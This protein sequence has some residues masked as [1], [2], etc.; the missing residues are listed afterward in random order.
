MAEQYKDFKEW[1][2]ENLDPI[3]QEVNDIIGSKLNDNNVISSWWAIFYQN[4]LA[5]FE[6]IFASPNYSN[7]IIMTLRLLMEIA[8]DV[9]F[10]SKNPEN[11]PKL[12]KRY[13]DLCANF[14]TMTYGEVGTESRKFRLYHFKNGKK[15]GNAIT[16]EERIIEAYNEDGV[17]FYYYLNGFSHFN[18]FGIMYGM[19]LRFNQGA[20]NMIKERLHLLKFYP[21]AYGKIIWAIGAIANVEELKKYNPRK[22]VETVMRLD[23]QTRSDKA[24][25]VER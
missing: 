12:Q 8:S 3:Y 2:L 23:L 10:V 14:K 22:M 6:M 25:I 1:F 11:I 4:S 13:S 18:H 15:K 21:A 9:E 20:P 24:K 5:L 17:L 16:T 19:D 7:Q